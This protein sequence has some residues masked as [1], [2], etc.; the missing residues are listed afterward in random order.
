MRLTA[1][2]LMLL[3]SAGLRG[4]QPAAPQTAAPKQSAPAEGDPAKGKILFASCS[5]C[6]AI[7][8]DQRKM[9]PSL[10]SLFGRVT[11]RNG[12][13]A[14][15]A[16]VRELILEG[17]NGMPSFR[18][19]FRPA[20]LE[21][22]LAFL[23]TLKAPPAPASAA[24][25]GEGLFRAF[26][27]RCHD[28]ASRT[29]PGPDLRGRYSDDWPKIVNEGHAGAPPMNEWMDE[30]ARNSLLGYLRSGGRTP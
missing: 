25:N 1:V 27:L 24:N 3:L 19:S 30:A 18:Y 8:S 23:H 11:L 29:A 14:D 10:R 7:D 28:A 15:D 21:D 12:K 17:F 4:Q 5:G 22:L 6:H 13:R 26:C 9:G 16:N 2:L 20:E